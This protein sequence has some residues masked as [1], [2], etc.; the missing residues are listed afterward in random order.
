MSPSCDESGRPQRG[1]GVETDPTAAL[2]S[3]QLP[4]NQ[5]PQAEQ[6]VPLP[7][8]DILGTRTKAIE[9]GVS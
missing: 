6:R 5:H 2:P 3:Q 1:A 9:S 4:R 8:T 7:R